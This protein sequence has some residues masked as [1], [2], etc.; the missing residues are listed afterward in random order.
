MMQSAGHTT[1]Y[2]V[3]M[4]TAYMIGGARTDEL[5]EICVR[6][7]LLERVE[8]AGFAQLKF[9]DVPEF[10]HMRLKSEVDSD[11]QRKADNTNPKL[12]AAIRLRDGDCCRWCGMVT[13]WGTNDRKSGRVGTFDHLEPG[14]PGTVDTM[15][16]ACRSCNSSRQDD[17]AG[18]DTVLRDPPEVRHYS[19]S[20]A[21]FILK[22][23]G[24]SVTVCPDQRAAAA[25]D[26]VPRSDVA[27]SGAALPDARVNAGSVD[28]APESADLRGPESGFTGSGRDGPGRAGSEGVGS[29][30]AGQG[31]A[32]SRRGRRSRRTRTGG[33]PDA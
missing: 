16:I 15:V 3:D 13:F 11:R 6:V 22:H 8:R 29:V 24:I 33:M 23:L 26:A 25:V 5:I 14:Q 32:R 28:M 27:P 31:S 21:A 2:L 1:D 20:S 12:T 7:G 17:R 30:R 18:F 9:E 19:P 4:G 10:L